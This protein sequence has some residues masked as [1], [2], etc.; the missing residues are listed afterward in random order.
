MAQQIV[1]VQRVVHVVAWAMLVVAACLISLGVVSQRRAGEAQAD[2]QDKSS[3]TPAK[4]SQAA[5]PASPPLEPLGPEKVK[6]IEPTPSPA[7]AKLD[8]QYTWEEVEAILDK[9]R[10]E[11]EARPQALDDLRSWYTLL[12]SPRYTESKSVPEHVTKLEAWRREIPKSPTPLIALAKVHIAWAWEAR[13]PGLAKTV[14]NEGFELYADRVRKAHQFI[15]QAI[16]LEPKD[17]EAYAVLIEVA[18]DSGWAKEDTFAALERGIK[19]DPSYLF[20]YESMAIY[21]LPRWHGEPGD[22]AE[23]AGK[24]LERL[25]GDD[26]LDAYGHIAYQANQF[27]PTIPFFGGFDRQALVKAGEVM[28]RRYPQARNLPYFAAVAAMAASDREAAIGMRPRLKDPVA[29][30][31]PIWKNAAKEFHAWCDEKEPPE[32]LLQRVWVPRY[33]NIGFVNDEGELWYGIGNETQGAA[34]IQAETGEARVILSAPA[35]GLRSV[36]FDRNRQ[37]LVAAFGGVGLN[38][39][40]LWSLKRPNQPRM[41]PTSEPC[42]SVDINP[43]APQLACVS[44]KTAHTLDWIEGKEG[45]VMEL[46]EAAFAVGFSADGKSLVTL[47]KVVT[48]WDVAT[49]EKKYVLPSATM[50]PKPEIGCEDALDF[51]EEGRFWATALVLDSNPPERHVYRFSA[52]GKSWE[53]IGPNIEPA[54]GKKPHAAAL[55]VDRRLLAFVEP[56]D[57]ADG[58]EQI[59]IWE[60]KTGKLSKRLAGHATGIGMLAFSPNGKQLASIGKAGVVIKVW[61]AEP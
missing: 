48:V 13:G 41:F 30:R 31:V 21:L 40:A 43:K 35:F 56:A 4:A 59:Q 53:A 23:F 44:G 54:N 20:M 50:S 9:L 45:K 15:Q 39:W 36:N 19:L 46:S 26:A 10:G 49:A 29:V 12:S 38:G 3:D 60:L 25:S 47:D 2:G 51:D 14:S 34:V 1:T 11:R 57:G 22:L 18:K 32:C 27:D 37:L 17:G 7:H 5:K 24:T 16:D 58:P 55:S 8:R 6:L 61:N 52:D 33:S 42:V 28:L